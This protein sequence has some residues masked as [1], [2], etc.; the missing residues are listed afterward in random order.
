MA[1]LNHPLWMPA[2]YQC[3]PKADLVFAFEIFLDRAIMNVL[4]LRVWYKHQP[5]AFG[6]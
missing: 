2:E 3:L 6:S 4:H 5:I 1:I